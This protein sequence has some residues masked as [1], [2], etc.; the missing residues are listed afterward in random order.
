[1]RNRSTLLLAGVVLAVA[2][3]NAAARSDVS[4]GIS[5]GVP[6]APAPV[7]VSSPPVVYYPPVPV[8]YYGPA[9]RVYYAPAYYGPPPGVVIKYRRGGHRHHW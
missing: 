6:V 9:S 5:I 8:Y 3:A 2:S 7:Y 4:F 1:M